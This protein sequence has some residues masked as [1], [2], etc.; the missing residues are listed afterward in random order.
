MTDTLQ[1]DSDSRLTSALNHA[2]TVFG[3]L[4]KA[5]IVVAAVLLIAFLRVAIQEVFVMAGAEFGRTLTILLDAALGIPVMFLLGWV[6]GT[7]LERTSGVITPMRLGF[8][9]AGVG[10]VV[11]LVAIAA[12][13]DVGFAP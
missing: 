11:W 9:V 7:I 8:Q 4:G 6:T 2:P 5:A 10:A 13:V 12:G 1:I 3:A